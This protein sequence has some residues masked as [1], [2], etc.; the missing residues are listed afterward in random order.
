LQSLRLGTG[1][2]LQR[3]FSTFAN[4]CPGK[5]LLILRLAISTFLIHD[6]FAPLM[7]AT[8][9]NHV[10]PPIIAAAVGVLLFAGLWTPIAG[11][12]VALLELWIAFS[13]QD[14]FW[15]S[16]LASAIASGLALLGPGAWSVDALTYGRRRISIRAR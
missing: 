14:E 5:G 13:R 1:L 7:G 16:L 4:G 9:V 2:I 11:A 8:N 15:A 10:V 3:L 12:L 6:S